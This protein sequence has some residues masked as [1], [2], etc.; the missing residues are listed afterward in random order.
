MNNYKVETYDDINEFYD[1][2]QHTSDSLHI[3]ATSAL[4]MHLKGATELRTYKNHVWTYANLQK[5]LYREWHK[6]VSGVKM[7]IEIRTVLEQLCSD[8]KV[9]RHLSKDIDSIL[10]DYKLYIQC[11]IGKLEEGVEASEQIKILR[12]VFNIF[13]NSDLVKELYYDFDGFTKEDLAQRINSYYDEIL[14]PKNFKE[15]NSITEINKVYFYNLTHI[16]A[17]RFRFF[18]KLSNL[19]IQVI[20]RIPSGG[21]T[22]PW[23]K[24]MVLFIIAIGLK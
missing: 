7:K 9:Y 4:S 3:V 5:A 1:K 8:A 24:L 16:D 6:A 18:K 2:L 12:K 17:T 15:N 19:G 20:F 14:N 13:R 21:F 23:K 11:G 22:K 10:S